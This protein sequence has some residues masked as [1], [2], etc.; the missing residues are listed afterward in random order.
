MQKTLVLV[1]GSPGSLTKG[2][3][4]IH[5]VYP[6]SKITLVSRL[7]IHK[8]PAWENV[9]AIKQVECS[10]GT[11]ARIKTYWSWLKETRSDCFDEAFIMATNEGFLLLKLL[12]LLCRSRSKFWINENG[13]WFNVR[14]VR[15]SLLHVRWRWKEDSWRWAGRAALWTRMIVLLPCVLCILALSTFKW[16]LKR[17]VLV[18]MRHHHSEAN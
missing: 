18:P 16:Y 8:D 14:A 3:G 9:V 4:N 1:T 6:H 17:H 15:A 11:L 7:P 10:G 2:L 12:S 13:D 5:R